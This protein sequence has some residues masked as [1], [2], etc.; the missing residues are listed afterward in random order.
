MIPIKKKK[1]KAEWGILRT[2]QQISKYLFGSTEGASSIIPRKEVSKSKLNLRRIH[3][4]HHRALRI[5][6]KTPRWQDDPHAYEY[7]AVMTASVINENGLVLGGAGDILAAFDST[8]KVRGMGVM[9]DGIGA[10]E[11][12]TLHSLMLRS[13][14]AGDTINFKYYDASANAILNIVETYTFI[15]NDGPPAT[16]NLITPFPFTLT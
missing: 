11:G 8:G 5:D 13:N 15:I 4:N 12:L 14:T 7:T 10:S 1:W 16:G 2:F 6:G 9:L 3:Q